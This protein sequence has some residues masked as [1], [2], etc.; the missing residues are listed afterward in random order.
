[1]KRLG[2]LVAYFLLPLSA[3]ESGPPVLQYDGAPLTLPFECKED[4]L[5]WAGMTCV[6]EACPIY[7]ELSQAVGSGNVII[8]SGNFHAPNATLYSLVLRTDDG[9]KTWREPF[10]RIR[11]ATLDRL[12]MYN[13]QSAWISGQLMQ[14]IALDPFFLVT[15]DG[16]QNWTRVP[17]LEEGTPGAITQFVFDSPDHGTAIVDRGGGEL[18]YE[19]YET[20]TGGRSWT[21]VR[22]SVNPPTLKPAQE[23]EWR[24][25]PEP[26][27]FRLEHFEGGRWAPS[28]SF[29]LNAASCRE[30]RNELAEPP[31]T[32][33]TPDAAS[34][35]VS[36]IH[37]TKDPKDQHP[38]NTK[39]PK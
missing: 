8:V 29:A 6:D 5:Q 22:K 30:K 18:R 13:A 21:I 38:K 4:D 14:P 34:D 1:M 27:L 2:V 16:G 20:Q 10:E 23:S 37:L 31:P 26:K 33:E 15:N 17:L 39:P 32:T 19:L 9:G 35:A 3:Q 25:R 11:G 7:T 24:M 28:V 36:E 12:E